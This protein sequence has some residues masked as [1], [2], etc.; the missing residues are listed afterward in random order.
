MTSRTSDLGEI[1]PVVSA[2]ATVTHSAIVAG[3][4]KGCICLARYLPGVGVGGVGGGGG[5][6]VN[7]SREPQPEEIKGTRD[8]S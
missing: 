8:C 5:V 3:W 1:P 4:L 6:E 2:D 7:S